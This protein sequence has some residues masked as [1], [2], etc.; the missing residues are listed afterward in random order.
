MPCASLP[1]YDLP[2]LRRAT[3][4]W[5][6]GIARALRREGVADVP[7]R[8]DRER[9]RAAQW[10]DPALLLSQTCGYPLRHAFADALRPVATPGYA[11]PGCDGPRYCSLLVVPADHPARGLADLR[12]GRVAYNAADSQSGYN[13]LRAMLAPL[14]DGAA[15][16]GSTLATGSHNASLARVAA[17]EADLAS[18]DCVTHA[19]LAR[20]QPDALA[21][22]RVLQRSPQAPGLPYVTRAAADA[23]LLQRLRAGLAAALADPDLAA[24]RDD[25]LLRSF[26]VIEAD[27]YAAI[28]A[29]ERDALAAG[30]PELV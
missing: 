25:L 10:R 19:L 27:G 2:M 3:D 9:D 12:G 8:L 7:D 18:I 14:A 1:M 6:A 4:A 30:Y 24:V 17:G 26:T 28:D 23:D 11:A 22:T 29:F 5:W 15:F 20:H 21:G 16:F 13:V